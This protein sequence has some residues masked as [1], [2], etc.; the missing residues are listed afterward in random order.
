MSVEFGGRQAGWRISVSPGI[1]REITR[2]L[3]TY[4]SG[5][6]YCISGNEYGGYYSTLE[7][8]QAARLATGKGVGRQKTGKKTNP[9][10]A[11][12][13]F[14]KDHKLPWML[15]IKRFQFRSFFKTK[16][17]AIAARDAELVRRGV[18]LSTI[19]GVREADLVALDAFLDSWEP[20]VTPSF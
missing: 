7:A 14:L 9:E 17:E 13:S 3:S 4:P 20:G 16:A 10:D 18:P 2:D 12:L 8:A 15:T 19:Y 5:Y 11:Y 1:L 6:K